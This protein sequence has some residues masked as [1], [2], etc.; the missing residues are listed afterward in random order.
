LTPRAL[1]PFTGAIA[2]AGL[3]AA[4]LATPAQAAK[5]K[6]AVGAKLA[7]ASAAKDIVKF[8]SAN[9]GENFKSA[10]SASI[11]WKHVPKIVSSGGATADARPGVVPAIG[12]AKKTAAA[13][14]NINLPK[15]TGLVFFVGADDQPYF[16]AGSSVQSKHRNVV[17][18]AGHCAYDTDHDGHGLDF[19]VFIPGFYDG[20]A[21]WGVYVGKQA[22]THYDFDVYE[23]YDRDYAFVTVYNGLKWDAAKEAVVDAG[24]LGDNVGG[25]GVAWNQKVGQK[26]FSI[27][28]PGGPHPDGD[29]PYSG[30][31]PKWCYGKTAAGVVAKDFKVDEQIAIKCSMTEGASGGPWLLKYKSGSRLGYVNGVTSLVGDLDGNDRVDITTSPYFDGETA[32]VY[33]AA[34]NVWSGR[35]PREGSV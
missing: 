1:L 17:A 6:Y 4:S 5:P 33:R 3:L 27:G 20:K 22:F 31:R 14:K 29:R 12:A 18:T 23:D 35:L 34:A 7:K 15:T 2:V 24:R 32:A 28:Y 21:P 26:V 8:W 16:C 9:G 25:Q 19:W 11:D 13:S 30:W 10:K